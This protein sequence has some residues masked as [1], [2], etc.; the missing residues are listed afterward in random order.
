MSMSAM[1]SSPRPISTPQLKM[2]PSVH[3]EPINRVIFPGSYLV[4]Q[5]DI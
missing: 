2:L 3:L 1:R 4:T 5:W